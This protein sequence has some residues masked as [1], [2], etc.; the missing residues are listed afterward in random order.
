[1]YEFFQI[2][3]VNFVSS[4]ARYVYGESIYTEYVLHILCTFIQTIDIFLPPDI[5]LQ[6]QCAARGNPVFLSDS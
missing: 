4:C 1:M 6:A 3:F 2:F 5:F